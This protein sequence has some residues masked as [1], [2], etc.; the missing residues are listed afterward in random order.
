MN[1][2]L[3]VISLFLL[4]CLVHS[5]DVPSLQV[6]VTREMNCAETRKAGE[7]DKV[8]VHYGGFLRDGTKFDS[9]FDRS[10]PFT[11]PLGKGKVIP[12]WDSGLIGV[13]PGEERHLV[14]PSHLA[15]GDRGAGDV[16]P[17]GATLLF[18]IVV[19]KIEQV[20]TQKEIQ[21]EQNRI[22]QQQ[23]EEEEKRRAEEAQKLKE[24][25]QVADYDYYEDSSDP[26]GGGQLQ[27][28]VIYIPRNCQKK[29]R[30]GDKL[31]MHY[32]GKLYDTGVKFDSSRDRNKAF[33]FT[34][35]IGQVIA[36]W[37]EGVKD[38]CVGE[39]RT[40]VV[41]P[42]MAYGE[43]G[44]GNVIPECATLIFE[45]ELVDIKN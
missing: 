8:T 42:G 6:D 23:E 32:T 18:D 33:D 10:K 44:V 17:P 36:G 27:Q 16:I 21:E 19:V 31:S 12:G 34:L 3:R 1:Y 13:C 22:Q 5:K 4:S 39:K 41:P 29:S 45:V 40:L 20:P 15:Y 30:S 37:D 9:S 11:F 7:G 35:G 2:P 26:C 38:M 24:Q 14:V 25:Q 28:E 43:R